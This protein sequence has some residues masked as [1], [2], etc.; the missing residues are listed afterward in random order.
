MFLPAQSRSPIQGSL[1]RFAPSDTNGAERVNSYAS[2]F[3]EKSSA[4]I[5]LSSQVT[6]RFFATAHFSVVWQK[7]N[8]PAAQLRCNEIAAVCICQAPRCRHRPVF[9]TEGIRH[10]L[11]GRRHRRR[12]ALR[13]R[14]SGLL[15]DS[16]EERLYDGS[17]LRLRFGGYFLEPDVKSGCQFVGT[18]TLSI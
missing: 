17:S 15:H 7:P 8:E 13:L 3:P 16:L 14:R 1:S 4:K 18:S 9:G 5:N 2:R 6:F 10:L 12:M 11:H